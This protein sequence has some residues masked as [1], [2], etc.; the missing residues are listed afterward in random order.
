VLA[1]TTDRRRLILASLLTQAGAG[2]LLAALL[3][4][5]WAGP[6]R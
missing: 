6:A 4:A 1:D 5:G 3:F 2:A